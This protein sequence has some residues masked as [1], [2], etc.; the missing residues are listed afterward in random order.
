MSASSN[1]CINLSIDNIL[2]ELPKQ[3]ERIVRLRFGIS[4]NRQL[5]P[6]RRSC[7]RNILIPPNAHTTIE[8]A[9]CLKMSRNDVRKH[10]AVAFKMLRDK[11]ILDMFKIVL[12]NGMHSDA[13]LVFARVVFQEEI[14]Q[15]TIAAPD[16]SDLPQ[17][18]KDADGV[19]RPKRAGQRC[20][21]PQL[22]S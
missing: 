11:K 14:F 8:I 12:E 9:Q 10:E 20:A 3:Y 5:P 7:F 16:L 21:L 13:V 17:C 4:R 22:K 18:E 2:N 6:L 1:L 15:L 19:I